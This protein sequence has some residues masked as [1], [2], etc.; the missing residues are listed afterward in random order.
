MHKKDKYMK[1]GI[2]EKKNTWKMNTLEDEY[3]KIW[4]QEKMNTWILKKINT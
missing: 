3:M 1:R 2:H 4:I